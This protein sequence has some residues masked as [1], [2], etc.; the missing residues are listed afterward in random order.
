[1]KSQSARTLTR[2]RAMLGADALAGLS[3]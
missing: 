3:D 2:L 1:V